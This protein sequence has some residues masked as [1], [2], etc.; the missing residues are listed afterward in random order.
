MYQTLAIIEKA[1]QK[2]NRAIMLSGGMDSAVLLDILMTRS[3]EPNRPSHGVYVDTGL[4]APETLAHVK[5]LAA[6]YQLPLHIA[7]PK[8][9]P[10]VQWSRQG[11]PMLGRQQARVWSKAH[12]G[13][14]FGFKADCS[15]CCRNLKIAPGRKATKAL[16]C[17]VQLTGIRGGGESRLRGLRDIKDGTLSWV[18]VDK[19]WVAKPL[20]GWTDTMIARYARQNRLPEHPARAR[21]A[22]TIGCQPCGGGS[23][24]DSSAYRQMRKTDPQ[25][26]HRWIVTEALGRVIL[27]VRYDQPLPVVDAALDHLGGLKQVAATRPWVFDHTRIN[28]LPGNRK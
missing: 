9:T 21:G 18:K 26:W 13:K 3:R 1:A 23:Q 5:E 24:F 15:S 11:Y 10:Q 8:R 16:G 7:Y 27:S 28:P 17:A 12:K 19:V 4:D 20:A 2:G 14:G 25:T 22:V 6:R